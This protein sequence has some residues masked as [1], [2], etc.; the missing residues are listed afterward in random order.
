MV[1]LVLS[2][3]LCLVTFYHVESITLGG[4][5]VRRNRLVREKQ[6]T[7]EKVRKLVMKHMKML[8]KKK[9]TEDLT[10]VADR[11]L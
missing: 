8:L 5:W 9:M 1:A 6:K 7:D 3:F 2:I 10:K 4:N 11:L